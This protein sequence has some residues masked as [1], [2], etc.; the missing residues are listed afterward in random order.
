M[1]IK[2]QEKMD[3]SQEFVIFE[4]T[5]EIMIGISAKKRPFLFNYLNSFASA[6]VIVRRG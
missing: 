1:I 2:E 4:P 3:G 5:G 6:N